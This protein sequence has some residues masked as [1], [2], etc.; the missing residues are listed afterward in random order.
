MLAENALVARNAHFV[1]RMAGN[2]VDR[3]DLALAAERFCEPLGAC[4]APCRLVD[5]DIN[6][7]R[8]RDFGIGSDDEDTGFLR[9]GEDRIESRRAVRVDDDGVHAFADEVANMGDLA[10]HVDIGALDDHFDV[11]ALFFPRRSRS[12]GLV[13]H[14][15]APLAAHPAIGQ[16]DLEALCRSAQRGDGKRCNGSQCDCDEFFHKVLPNLE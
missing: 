5:A 11:D 14:L 9:L 13:D 8:R 4:S 15:G 1:G 10:G 7:I 6:G 16:A 12:L 2:A 3:H